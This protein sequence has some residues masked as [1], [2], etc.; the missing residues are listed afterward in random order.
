M[1][2]I[3][4]EIFGNYT[5]FNLCYWKMGYW[6]ADYPSILFNLYYFDL[7]IYHIRHNDTRQRSKMIPHFFISSYFNNSHL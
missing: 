2:S 7:I 5:D 1:M 3:L 4:R 6:V